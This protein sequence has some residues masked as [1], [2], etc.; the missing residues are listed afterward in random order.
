M[1]HL[2]DGQRNANHCRF[3]WVGLI[4]KQRSLAENNSQEKLYLDIKHNWL[5]VY[6][7][8]LGVIKGRSIALI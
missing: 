6:P 3:Q 5:Q 4:E 2:S 1:S 8:T 7:G